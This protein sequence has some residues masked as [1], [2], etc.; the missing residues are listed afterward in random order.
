MA[1]G[2]DNM[3]NSLVRSCGGDINVHDSTS[4]MDVLIAVNIGLI[5]ANVRETTSTQVDAAIFEHG[6]RLGSI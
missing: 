5:T 6:E 4:V 3:L 2:I 1:K